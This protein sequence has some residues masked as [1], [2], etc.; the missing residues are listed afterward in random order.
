MMMIMMMIIG[1]MPLIHTST[2]Y[3]TILIIPIIMNIYYLFKEGLMVSLR[4]I[5]ISYD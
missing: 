2:A 3:S 1:K 4:P 5:E